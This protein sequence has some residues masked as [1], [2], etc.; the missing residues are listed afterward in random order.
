MIYVVDDDVVMAKCIA[1]SCGE[2]EVKI[3]GNAI[4]VMNEISEGR[5][6]KMMFLDVLLTGPDGFTLLNEMVSYVDT[7]KV[8]VVIVTSLDMDGRDLSEY[9]VVG[10]LEKETM[11]PEDVRYYAEK[12]A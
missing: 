10:V 9:G 7:S 4:D 2:R 12:Y 3:F 6:P 8:P 11:K 1:R 5:L